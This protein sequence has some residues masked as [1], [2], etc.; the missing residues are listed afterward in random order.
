MAI[1]NGSGKFVSKKIR[2]VRWRP[3]AD[4]AQ[5]NTG[6]FATGSWDEEVNEV[7]LAAIS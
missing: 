5:A 7:L 3:R 6:V 1:T 4:S 2:K